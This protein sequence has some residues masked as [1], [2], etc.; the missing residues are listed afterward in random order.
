[1]TD[2]LGS[3]TTP[4]PIELFS[5]HQLSEESERD[6]DVQF[7]TAPHTEAEV[8]EP[9]QKYAVFPPAVHSSDVSLK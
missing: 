3:N 6:N 2:T 9:D 4:H 8:G 1:M 5:L 7:P